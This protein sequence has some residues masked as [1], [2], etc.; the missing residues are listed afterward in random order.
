MNTSRTEPRSVM[1]RVSGAAV[2]GAG[3]AY[4]AVNFFSWVEVRDDQACEKIDRPLLD[5]VGLGSHPPRFYKLL[6]CLGHRLQAAGHQATARGYSADDPAGTV[7]SRRRTSDCRLVDRR[8]RGRSVVRFPRTGRVDPLPGPGD[9]GFRDAPA[10]LA[11]R[12]VPL[13][14]DPKHWDAI[15]AH[16][17]LRMIT[18]HRRPS[19][20]SGAPDLYFR[21]GHGPSPFFRCSGLPQLCFGP[22]D[23]G[24]SPRHAPS[25]APTGGRFGGIGR[26]VKPWSSAS[27]W[28][29]SASS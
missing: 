2:A 22:C 13:R 25:E 15:F 1:P 8:H 23:G 26:R 5:L 19:D 14:G 27:S 9:H 12:P 7:P 10:C 6:D 21:A 20:V 18:A 29:F 16:A 17:S 11:R 4:G 3:L 28:R 24:A